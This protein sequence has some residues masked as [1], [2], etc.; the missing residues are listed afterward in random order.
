MVKKL[1]S[2]VVLTLV[3]AA[4][5]LGVGLLMNPAATCLTGTLTL[6]LI[7]TR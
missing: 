2:L 1:P 6:G 4:V 7:P 3:P 5:L